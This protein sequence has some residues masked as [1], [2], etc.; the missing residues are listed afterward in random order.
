MADNW[1][2]GAISDQFSPR[3]AGRVGSVATAALAWVYAIDFAAVGAWNHLHD[4]LTSG[5]D[6]YSYAPHPFREYFYTLVV[7]DP[8]VVVLIVLRRPIA[9]ILAAGVVAVDLLGNWISD[10]QHYHNDLGWLVGNKGGLIQ[11]TA[12]AVFV[13]ATAAPLRRSF[14]HRLALVGDG[15]TRPRRA[16]ADRRCQFR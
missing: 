1:P 14:A 15:S 9:P 6:A 11:L 3:S 12:F 2:D 7:L 13:F 10:W 5:L 16:R 8:V 4:L